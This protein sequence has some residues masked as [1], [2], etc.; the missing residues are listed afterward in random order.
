MMNDFWIESNNGNSLFFRK[1]EDGDFYVEARSFTSPAITIIVPADAM[2]DLIAWVG[3]IPTESEEVEKS[4]ER[5]NEFFR[6][7]SKDGKVNPFEPDEG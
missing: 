3:Y 4:L 5:E 7:A 2:S 6:K 1:R